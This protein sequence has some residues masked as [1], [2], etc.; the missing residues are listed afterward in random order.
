[1][2]HDPGAFAP[3]TIQHAP[4]SNQLPLS[5]GCVPSNPWDSPSLGTPSTSAQAPQHLPVAPQ[6][7]IFSCSYPGERAT[8]YRIVGQIIPHYEHRWTVNMGS[9]PHQAS[10][11]RSRVR[12]QQRSGAF[13][14][15]DG[16]SA[17][18]VRFRALCASKCDSLGGVDALSAQQ[19]SLVRRSVVLELSLE[20]MENGAAAGSPI[21]AATYAQASGTLLRILRSLGLKKVSTKPAPSLSNWRGGE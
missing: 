20:A 10:K 11:Q 2:T 15:D 7:L 16:R 3:A 14:L 5:G 4:R 13:A 21:D 12:T 8:L 19:L 17:Y 1:M 18:A 9:P 6:S